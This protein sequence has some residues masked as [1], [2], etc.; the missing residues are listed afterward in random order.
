MIKLNP[1]EDT[2]PGESI[3]S[4]KIDAGVLGKLFGCGENISKNVGAFIA[5]ILTLAIISMFIWG[6]EMVR[7]CAKI[8]I[9]V[10]TL[11]IGYLFGKSS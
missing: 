6:D 3:A 2:S 4:K 5:I 8:L 11:I 7:D 9:S 1:S 10:L